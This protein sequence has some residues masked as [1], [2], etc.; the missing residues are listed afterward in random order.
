MQNNDILTGSAAWFST[1]PGFKPSDYDYV[2]LVDKPIRFQFVRQTHGPKGCLFEWKRMAPQ[3]YINYALNRGPA[4]QL[5]KFLTPE[6]VNEIGFTIEHLK[7]LQPLVD[8]LDPKHSYQ[9]IIFDSYVLNNDF[10]LTQEQLQQAYICY[11]DAR[12]KK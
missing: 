12:T 10:I 2:R 7:Q 5:G 9:K 4:M 8:N 11:C 1:I 3:D 6:F